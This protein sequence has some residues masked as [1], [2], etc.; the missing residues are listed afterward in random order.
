MSKYDKYFTRD[1]TLHYAINLY[2]KQQSSIKTIIQ[3]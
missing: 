2:K 3:Y 1:L